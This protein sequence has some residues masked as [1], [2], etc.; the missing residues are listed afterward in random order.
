MINRI[1]HVLS[2]RTLK[3]FLSMFVGI[4]LI[5]VVAEY[6]GRRL[7]VIE[8]LEMQSY[9]WR[10]SRASP[11]KNKDIVIVDIDRESL[12]EIG[13]WPW[14]RD[15]FILLS[16]RLFKKY[17]ARIIAYTMPF[18]DASDTA[19]RVLDDVI[20]RLGS[21][22]TLPTDYRED[23]SSSSIVNNT[24][25]ENAALQTLMSMR[26]SY[27]YDRAFSK[28]LENEP[29]VF[30]Y[31]FSDLRRVQGALPQPVKFFYIGQSQQSQVSRAALAMLSKQW[32]VRHGYI[33]NL[34]VLIKA[35]KGAAGHMEIIKDDDGIVR[36][37]PLFIRHAGRYYD[38]LPMAI[39]RRLQGVLSSI[40]IGVN[41]ADNVLQQISLG[42]YFI[43]VNPDDTLYLNFKGSG[44]RSADFERKEGAI[45][46]Y[47]SASDVMNDRLPQ[48]MLEDKIVIIGSTSPLLGDIHSTPV[49]AS[50]P[51]AEI[52]AVQ[53]ASMLEGDI[54]HR[55][56]IIGTYELLIALIVVVCLSWVFMRWGPLYSLPI[57]A[58]IVVLHVLFVMYQWHHYSTVWVMVPLLLVVSGLFFF[59]VVVGFVYEWRS[60]YRLRSTF[61]RYVPPALAE[62]ISS[63]GENVNL[64]GEERELSV[65]FS[66]VR[67]FTTLSERLSPRELTKVINRILDVLT[68]AV[69]RHDGTVD[70]YIGD[71][72]MAF[73][74]APLY[75]Q[76][77]AKKAVFAA[78][79]MQKAMHQ[80]SE[81][82][83]KIG[84]QEM[85]LGVGISTGNTNVGN[86][87]SKIRMA[88]TAIGDNVN[89]AS[90]TEGMTKR[91]GV[92]ILV[93][94]A[95]RDGCNDDDNLVFR[96]ID[97]V[98]VKGREAPV[99]L[100]QP[101][102]LFNQMSIEVIESLEMFEQMRQAYAEGN[103]VQAARWLDRY[104]RLQPE[105]AVI[106]RVYEKRLRDLQSS[107]PSQWDGVFTY[108]TK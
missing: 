40:A 103:F 84:Y 106:I 47:V 27:D 82:F 87:G 18:P 16:D 28:I 59:N 5:I 81:E 19:V 14:L 53:L 65:L 77:H 108:D 58:A 98:R 4:V 102:G 49:N 67:N 69:H 54:L 97:T 88:Y 92:P 61:S 64:E 48:Q 33:G 9:D 30:G 12:R 94:Q 86:M 66:D 51:A 105:D 6:D 25:P 78:L 45:F 71:A 32:P 93:T 34:P 36:R 99:V 35:A 39:V 104:S 85:K 90:R 38:S 3:F 55:P 83:V 70:K 68:E 62:R 23:A 101:I 24:Q 91:Y 56:E 96:T 29:A 44:G 41:T 26:S 73:W 57:F 22:G 50:M 46:R 7:G 31:F 52:V 107:V 8:M 43:N 72:L 60:S 20:I 79:D 2:G 76:A 74:N 37:V 75:D 63:M 13:N 21:G 89:L 1:K 17:R 10:L 11:Y 80:L 42:R 95:T 100:Y 15:K